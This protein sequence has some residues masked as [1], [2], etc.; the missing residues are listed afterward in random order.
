MRDKVPLG[1]VVPQQE[2]IAIIPARG[3]SKGIHRKNI[4]MLNG[5]PLI[6]Y[7][8]KVAV[9]SEMITRV[10]VSTDD[11]EIAEIA[12]SFGAE[13]PFLRPAELAS[14]DSNL[15]DGVQY[16]L[17]KVEENGERCDV[18]AI[19]LPTH[20][21]R[22]V[23][24]VDE[25]I[26]ILLDGCTVVSTM[27]E[28]Q[29]QAESYFSIG[30]NGLLMPV[31]KENE[32]CDVYYRSYGLFT[33]FNRTYKIAPNGMYIHRLTNPVSLIDID[34]QSDLAIAED[35]IVQGLFDFGFE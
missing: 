19:M 3:G 14:D 5:L 16:T 20:P 2:V 23:G 32:N 33:A 11:E 26:R 28:I 29:V 31:F 22:S 4:A 35:V 13:V 15:N 9:T 34:Y 12:I 25:L 27:R 17:Q 30:D 18:L 6:A 7:T 21:F 8:I 10:I 24:M 1:E